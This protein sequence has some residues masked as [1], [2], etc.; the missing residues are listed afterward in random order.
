MSSAYEPGD[1]REIARRL[2]SFRALAG[3]DAK[4]V[5]LIARAGSWFCLPGGAE[6][7]RAGATDRCLFFVLTGTVS[8]H[9]DDG[10]GALECV[11]HVPAG[12]TLGEMSLLTDEEH[13]ARLFAHRDVE[14]FALERR[15]F[16]R[17]AAEHPAL[18]R[19]LSLL[20]VERLRR[21]TQR[22]AVRHACRAVALVAAHPSVE[23][24]PLAGSLL[25][26]LAGL[27]VRAASL[28]ASDAGRPADWYHAVEAANDLVLYLATPHDPVWSRQ[29]ERRADRVMLVLRDVDD[30]VEPP[31]PTGR[32]LRK[33][34]DRIV[35]A[36]RTARAPASP[37]GDGLRHLVRESRADDVQR[38]AR[39]VAGRAVGLVL[40]GGGA[41]GFAHVGV[42]KAL[43]E[44]SIP[45]DAVGGTS[46]G[47][48]VAAGVALEWTTEELAE[49]MREAFVATNPISDLTVPT[50]AFFGGRKV[51]TLLERAFGA[52]RIEETP[53]PFFCVTSDL[54]LGADE[55][56][57]AGRVAD[58]LRASVAIPG[59]LPPV[60]IDGRV[61][62]DGGIMNN[63]PVDHMGRL[64]AGPVIAVDVSG[65]TTLPASNGVSAPNILSIL[66][67][68]GTVGNEWQRREA[69][70][71]AAVLLDP[72][73]DEIGFRD[74]HAFERA[75][76]IGEAHA[77]ARLSEDAGIFGR[78]G[79]AHGPSG[80]ARTS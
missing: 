80:L 21:T 61:H 60:V 58:K 49:R 73:I 70:R 71:R 37:V 79:L 63:L 75:V 13:S 27:G 18:L 72:P 38:L 10:R 41:R 20:L 4:A 11:A 66:I 50:V 25:R 33:P 15:A 1:S 12:E 3:L 26:A 46:M 40:S 14:L 44:A 32:A 31:A 69:R 47:A 6:L 30:D 5:R 59:I 62:V 78:L 48:I 76:A 8:V 51:R 64:S 29:A 22:V 45:I 74:W 53:L 17:V 52:A 36:G 65:D 9:V 67:R 42:V 19:N 2:S 34:A 39:F 24:A 77:W 16:E 43:R 54:T 35:L 56:H 57:R 23:V 68:T 28:D 7:E 55:A